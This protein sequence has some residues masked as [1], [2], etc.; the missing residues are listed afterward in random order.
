MD[1]LVS[2]LTTGVT[3]CFIGSSG[4]GKSSIINR[5]AG[6]ELL[7]TA[8]VREADSRGRHTTSHRELF[9]LPSGGIVIDTPGMRE[10]G[11]WDAGRGIGRAF[12]DIEALA[13]ACAFSDCTHRVEPGC[14]VRL[15]VEA[16]DLDRLR[17]ESLLKL[18]REQEH[19]DAK[20]DRFKQQER[21]AHDKSI[22]KAVKDLYKRKGR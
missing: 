13:M 5:L 4:V 21:K 16:G 10:L 15:A 14:A 12:G 19:L 6:R 2:L 7:R 18:G 20:T 3:A 11:L 8:E 1:R 17:Y 9:M 22:A